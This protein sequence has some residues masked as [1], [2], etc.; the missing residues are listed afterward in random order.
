MDDETRWLVCLDMSL[1]TGILQH[2]REN[3]TSIAFLLENHEG[4]HSDKPQKP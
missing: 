4:Q 2:M 3:S 1:N